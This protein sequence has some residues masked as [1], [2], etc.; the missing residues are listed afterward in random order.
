MKLLL[1]CTCDLK[2]EGN[3]HAYNWQI[4]AI[5][6]IP[7]ESQKIPSEFRGIKN[8][9]I[10]GGRTLRRR[11]GKEWKERIRGEGLE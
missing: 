7:L 11:K 1:P 10:M 4:P 2:N 6:K 3:C 5:E 9:R 8:V